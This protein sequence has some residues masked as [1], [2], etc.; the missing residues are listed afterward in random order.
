MTFDERDL[1]ALNR[2]LDGLNVIEQNAIV[3]KGLQEAAAMIKKK[4]KAKLRATMS[5]DAWNVKMRKAMAAKRGGGLENAIGTRT[6]KKKGKA[7]IGFNKLGH[8]AHLVNMGTNKRWKKDGQPTGS[9]SKNAPKT[10]SLFW[11]KNFQENREKAKNIIID[12]VYASVRKLGW[13]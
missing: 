6:F 12:S 10:G 8:H 7:H 13:K 4:G 1:A 11:T 9:V 3:Q 2:A 5:T